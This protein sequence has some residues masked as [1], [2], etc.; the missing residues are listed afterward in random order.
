MSED[1][2]TPILLSQYAASFDMFRDA[3]EK[4]SDEDWNSKDYKTQT[5]QIAF[6]SLFF[7]Y[8]YLHKKHA[9][10]KPLEGFIEGAEIY[11]SFK[12]APEPLYSRSQIIDYISQC[13]NF[14]KEILPQ[15][16]L[17]AA[18]GFSWYET[19]KLEHQ[20]INIRH[21]QHHTAQIADRLR[22]KADTNT[23]WFGWRH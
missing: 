11:D 22:N 15:S 10:F 6:H 20:I 19:S 14:A 16:D 7:T 9:D 8:L 21:I 13:E 5:W 2:V 17:N 12:D 4:T 18:S 23:N 3:V 1:N